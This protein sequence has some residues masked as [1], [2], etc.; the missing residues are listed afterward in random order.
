MYL[1]VLRSIVADILRRN[2]FGNRSV[3]RGDERGPGTMK[4]TAA[5]ILIAIGKAEGGGW[6]DPTD[7][8]F[9]WSCELY[10][11]A[12]KRVGDGDAHTP[13]EAMALAWLC[14]W[15]PDA[16]LNAHVEV[17]PVPFKV[18]DGWRFELTPPFA[19][20]IDEIANV[21]ADEVEALAQDR[22][23]DLCAR[24]KAETESES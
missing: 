13:Q 20:A 4:P 6:I 9:R 1:D 24:I 23:V 19:A 3:R 5:D 10:D 11:P 2:G 17:G 12:G 16:L 22:V 21:M 14:A 8:P 7:A 18:P 15:A